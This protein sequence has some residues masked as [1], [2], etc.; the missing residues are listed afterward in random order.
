MGHTTDDTDSDVTVSQTTR[1]ST[2][3]N[4][5]GQPKTSRYNRPPCSKKLLE[6]REKIATRQSN[7]IQ[8]MKEDKEELGKVLLLYLH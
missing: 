2:V 1:Q 7:R 3:K 8:Q 4:A 5:F 6:R